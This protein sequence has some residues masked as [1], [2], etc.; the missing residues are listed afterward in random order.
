LARS[1][2]DTRIPML[3]ISRF[4]KGIGMVHS[5]TDHVSFAKFVEANWGVPTISAASRDN[6]PNPTQAPWRLRAGQRSRDRRFDR[7][8]QLLI[9]SRRFTPLRG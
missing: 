5:Y 3:A 1:G 9:L 2:D 7:H 4:S 6:L 8:V